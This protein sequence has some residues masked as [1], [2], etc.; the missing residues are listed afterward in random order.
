MNEI[1]RYHIN[2]FE[3]NFIVTAA[4][5]TSTRQLKIYRTCS[6]K[7]KVATTALRAMKCYVKSANKYVVTEKGD[8]CSPHI[9]AQQR[10]DLLQQ[11]PTETVLV[12]M[13]NYFSR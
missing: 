1:G 3:G 12:Q 11:T 9:S 13:G 2:P 6:R 5:Q 7:C 4:T 8:H 10:V